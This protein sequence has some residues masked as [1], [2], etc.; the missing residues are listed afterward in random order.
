[1]NRFPPQF[2]ERS[3]RTHL[4]LPTIPGVRVLCVS[5]FDEDDERDQKNIF[6]KSTLS[7]YR[8]HS[9]LRYFLSRDTERD[10][11]K[12]HESSGCLYVESNENLKRKYNL[13][14]LASDGIYSAS[15]HISISIEKPSIDALK[16][17]QEIY[18]ANV[19]ENTTKQVNLLMVRVANLPMHRNV[20]YFIMNPNSF[21]VIRPTSGVI[22]TTGQ[23]FDRERSEHFLLLVQVR[24]DLYF[25]VINAYNIL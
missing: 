22:R 21:L 20:K 9:K 2:K 16:F 25:N 23:P 15:T 18:Y 6:Y 4:S 14:V 11:F 13:T 8:K 12:L 7:R 19:L 24:N 3:Y 17:S 5:A 10:H 1:M